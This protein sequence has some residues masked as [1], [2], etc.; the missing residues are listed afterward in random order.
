MQ[1]AAIIYTYA[2]SIFFLIYT[3]NIGTSFHSSRI[4][5]KYFKIH[6]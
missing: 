3:P 1:Q 2:E 4:D 6:V 5:I